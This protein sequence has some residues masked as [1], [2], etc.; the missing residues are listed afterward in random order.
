MNSLKSSAL[1]DLAIHLDWE[2]HGISHRDTFYADQLNCWRDAVFPKSPFTG[3]IEEAGKGNPGKVHARPGELVPE[4]RDDLVFDLDVLRLAPELPFERLQEG[5]FY[6]R[7]MITGMTGVF[8]ANMTPFRCIRIE[9]NRFTADFNH[10]LAGLELTLETEPGEYARKP[11]ERGGHCTDWMELVLSGPGMQARYDGEAT[12]FFSGRPFRRRDETPD[13]DFYLSDRFVPHIDRTASRNLSG[14]YGSILRPGDRVLD[15]M[16]SWESH[17]PC[18][19]DDPDV[20]GIGLNKNELAANP[21]LSGYT[22][23]DLNTDTTLHFSDRSFDLVICSLSVE[24]LTQPVRIFREA[25]RV[26]KPGGTF[27]AAFSNRWFPEKAIR[28][29]E[30][31]HDFERMGLVTEYVLESG[32]F[33]TVST[34]SIR[35]YPRPEDD[36]YYP[37]FRLSDPVYAVTAQTFE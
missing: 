2:K 13:P 24:Y 16:A 21:V 19:G 15:L 10:P 35:G 18:N 34:V 3:L 9:G 27:A 26:L 32:A 17:L 31:L 29:W 12:A 6:P 37:K 8:R 14:V 25:A 11:E 22:V 30:D 36:R 4:Y 1:V 33:E 28:I 7:G 5:R 20:H 23:Q